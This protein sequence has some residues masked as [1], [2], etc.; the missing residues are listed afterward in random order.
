MILDLDAAK[1]SRGMVLTYKLVA[2]DGQFAILCMMAAQSC[3]YWRANAINY[4]FSTFCCTEF[5]LIDYKE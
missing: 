4:F 2:Y 1:G 5:L 3:R